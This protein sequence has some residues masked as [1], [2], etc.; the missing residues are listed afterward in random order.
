MEGSGS[1]CGSESATLP[2]SKVARYCSLG[3]GGGDVALCAVAKF[4]FLGGGVGDLSLGLAGMGWS[5]RSFGLDKGYTPVEIQGFD[6]VLKKL[7]FRI[8]IHFFRIRIRIQRL[9]LDTNTDP[10]L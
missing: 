2:E 9:R 7:V 5:S 3:G 8:R 4:F 10:G 6:F 1:E